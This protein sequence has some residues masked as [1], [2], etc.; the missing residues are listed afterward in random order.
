[1]TEEGLPRTVLMTADGVGGV[2]D[3]AITLATSLA[4]RGVRTVLALPDGPLSPDRLERAS[5]VPGLI[6]E[7][8]R[9]RLE[10]EPGAHED[11]GP[12]GA[13]LCAL[14]R[15]YRPDLVHINGYDAAALPFAAPVV[16]AAHS[17]VASWFEAVDRVEPPATFAGYLEALRRGLARADAVIA[18]SRAMLQAL[19]RLHGLT[20]GSV[21]PNGV[22]LDSI[23][24]GPGPRTKEDFV[25]AAGRVWDRAKNLALLDAVAPSI[26]RPVVIAGERR[27]PDGAETRLRH[28]Q[29]L[30]RVSFEDMRALRARAAVFCAPALYEPFG[31]AILEAAAAGCAL[32]LS[33]IASL[34]ETWEGAAL[35]V[36]PQDGRALVRA[37]N[38]PMGDPARR[39]D[40]AERA[41]IRARRYSARAM[42]DATLAVYAEA[43]A[44]RRRPVAA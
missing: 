4:E 3:Y 1:M 2:F 23:N 38:G 31:L 10:W 14:E 35:F 25:L 42:A 21:V 19:R 12:C 18:P 11:R 28:A 44:R 40:L 24:A 9:F 20:G 39:A 43:S 6:L 27:A 8:G 13:W 34:R 26:G 41:R 7:H 33:D 17:C 37:L 22:D 32:V 29:G 15:R 36:R 30:G 16:C 5:R